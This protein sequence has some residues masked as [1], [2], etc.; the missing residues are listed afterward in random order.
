MKHTPK[1][2]SD[3]SS[4]PKS[5]RES[6]WMEKKSPDLYSFLVFSVNTK[7]VLRVYFSYYFRCYIAIPIF[8]IKIQTQILIYKTLLVVGSLL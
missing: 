7:N 2:S 8:A 3:M 1:F 6:S 5:G 4:E